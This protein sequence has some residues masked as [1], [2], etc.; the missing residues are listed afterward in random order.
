MVMGMA[1]NSKTSQPRRV[2]TPR[3]KRDAN[4]WKAAALRL[5]GTT[6]IRHERLMLYIA[7]ATPE[8]AAEEAKTHHSNNRGGLSRQGRWQ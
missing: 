7:G 5:A 4:V 1:R 6:T 8:Q 2:S 3:Q